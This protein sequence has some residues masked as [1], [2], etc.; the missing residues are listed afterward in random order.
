M[1][2][3]TTPALIE[4]VKKG[5]WEEPAAKWSSV[6][7]CRVKLNSESNMI[8]EMFGKA[9]QRDSR[10]RILQAGSFKFWNRTASNEH[11]WMR[12]AGPKY[13]LANVSINCYDDLNTNSIIDESVTGLLCENKNQALKPVEKVFH[14]QGCFKNV[15][16]GEHDE[17]VLQFNGDHLIYCPNSTILINSERYEC[18]EHIFAVPIGQSFELERFRFTA[19]ERL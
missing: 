3:H 2:T 17:Q 15:T 1:K 4:Y 7:K 19:T 10:L 14:S 16:I 6:A 13:I 9:P 5:L 18:P 8:L 12:Y 11:C